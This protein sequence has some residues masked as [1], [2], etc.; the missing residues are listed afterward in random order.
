MII[1]ADT[2]SYPYRNGQFWV[3][4]WHMWELTEEASDALHYTFTSEYAED[5]I[6]EALE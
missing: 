1:I 6:I 3:N 4:S 2:L 5:D